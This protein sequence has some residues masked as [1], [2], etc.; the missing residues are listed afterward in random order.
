MET[1]SEYY[2]AWIIYLLAVAAAQLLLWKILSGI[3]N[4]DITT[5]MQLL[6]LAVLI[7]PASLEQS[8]YWVPSFMAA[9]MEGINLGFEAAL[10]RIWPILIA[11]FMFVGTSLLWAMRR[12]SRQQLSR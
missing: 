11:M 1:G 9:L 2:Y 7:V 8:G 6:L 12:R 10:P 3:K 5:V 4:R